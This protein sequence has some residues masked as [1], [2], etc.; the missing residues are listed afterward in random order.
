MG[1]AEP[2][3]FDT[4]GETIR[5]HHYGDSPVLCRSIFIQRQITSKRIRPEPQSCFRIRSPDCTLSSVSNH[6]P[7]IDILLRVHAE[8]SHGT[9]PL[10]CVELSWECQGW[11][12]VDRLPIPSQHTV[13]IGMGPV[14]GSLLGVPHLSPRSRDSYPFSCSGSRSCLCLGESGRFRQIR[15]RTRTRSYFVWCLP[16]GWCLRIG[17]HPVSSVGGHSYSNRQ[18]SGARLHWGRNHCADIDIHIYICAVCGEN[19]VEFPL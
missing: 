13:R 17:A 11:V 9:V 15:T 18:F 10:R 16:G 8:E 1:A 6:E 14:V 2:A 12:W 5:T 4:V 3:S 7:T 19:C